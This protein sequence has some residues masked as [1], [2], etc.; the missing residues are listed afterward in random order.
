M[1]AFLP[2]QVYKC[3]TRTEDGE[4]RDVAVKVQRPGILEEI[5]L[6]LLVPAERRAARDGQNPA[7]SPS[8]TTFYDRDFTVPRYGTTSNCT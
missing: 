5:A 3:R 1:R 6:D 4:V 8:E 2:P 7:A